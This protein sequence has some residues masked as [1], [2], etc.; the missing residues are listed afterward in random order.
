MQLSEQEIKADLNRL[1]DLSKAI[2]GLAIINSDSN[3]SE[4][5]AVESVGEPMD[6]INVMDTLSI[7]RTSSRNGNGR[8]KQ[9]RK[10]ARGK[11]KSNSQSTQGVA[12]G[13]NNFYK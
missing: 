7:E 11:E 2:N 4:A 9:V 3:G 6:D 8:A 12:K 1:R 10:P 5:C 13:N